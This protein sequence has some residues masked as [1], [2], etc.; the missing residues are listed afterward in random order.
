MRD[1]SEWG[2][3]IIEKNSRESWVIVVEWREYAKGWRER[4]AARAAKLSQL[5]AELLERS[6]RAACLLR[7][8]FD[9]DAVYLFGSVVRPSFS[10]SSDVDIAVAG[11][12]PTDY[13][14]AWRLVSDCL[15]WELDLILVE[16][17]KPTLKRHILEEGITV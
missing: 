17:A 6:K 11:L 3:G 8:E 12:K 2:H 13:L 15:E 7:T 16:E 10:D 4:E 5:R 1:D 9:V 14:Q